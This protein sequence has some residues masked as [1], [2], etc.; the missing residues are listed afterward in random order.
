LAS[1]LFC[2]H[3]VFWGASPP[4]PHGSASPRFGIKTGLLRSRTTLFAS[5]LEKEEE[6][7]PV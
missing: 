4:D 1:V 5:F 6:H 3:A 7:K 2:P